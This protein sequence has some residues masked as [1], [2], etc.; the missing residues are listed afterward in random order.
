MR[1]ISIILFGNVNIR[2]IIRMNFKNC[3]FRCLSF[4]ED[5]FN[6]DILCA[7]LQLNRIQRSLCNAS[8]LW[9][10]G[11]NTKSVPYGQTNLL[12]HWIWN[13][14][15]ELLFIWITIVI[16]RISTATYTFRHDGPCKGWDGWTYEE[17]GVKP[18][19]A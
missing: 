14:Y 9:H 16:T 13:R 2:F 6:W 15:F 3:L 11:C 18:Y 12:R 4:V 7:R 10:R 19:F 5:H 17:V 8:Q 1:I